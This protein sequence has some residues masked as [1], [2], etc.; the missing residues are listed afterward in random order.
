VDA[1]LFAAVLAAVLVFIAALYLLPPVTFSV[2]AK[3]MPV[4]H[5]PVCHVWPPLFVTVM[6]V[7]AQLCSQRLH[8][9]Q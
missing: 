1:R 4:E 3:L 5:L 2:F 9:T 8:R 7:A 6:I